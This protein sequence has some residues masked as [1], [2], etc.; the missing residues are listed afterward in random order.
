MVV[1]STHEVT[2]LL[3]AWTTGDERALEK[4]TPLV[5]EQLR[6]VAE[7]EAIGLGPQL[8]GVYRG[9][10]CYAAGGATEPLRS[11]AYRATLTFTLS[12]TTP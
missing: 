8:R 2:Q 11:G 7:H 3:K 5:Y 1:P 10:M 6:R 4:L 9:Q 12:T